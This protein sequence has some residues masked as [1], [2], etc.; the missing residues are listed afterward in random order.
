MQVVQPSQVSPP[1]SD[2]WVL[3]FQAKAVAWAGTSPL[4]HVCPWAFM[5]AMQRDTHSAGEPRS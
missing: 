2:C 4:P 1:E 3:P 5:H